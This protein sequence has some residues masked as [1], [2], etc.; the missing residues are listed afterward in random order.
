MKEYVN[1]KEYFNL[2]EEDARDLA[3]SKGFRARVLERDD[4]KFFVTMDARS[5]R[6]NFVIKDGKVVSANIR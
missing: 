4:E 2:T 6:V 3:K 1:M 5:D